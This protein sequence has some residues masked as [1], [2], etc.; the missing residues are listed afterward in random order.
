MDALLVY[1]N[2][3]SQNECTFWIRGSSGRLCVDL[4]PENSAHLWNAL[5]APIPIL[6]GIKPSEDLN[7][8]AVA[9]DALTLEQYHDI[10]Y[11]NLREHR[12]LYCSTSAAVNLNAMGKNQQKSTKMA[13]S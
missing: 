3:Q 13:I 6:S 8:E 11:W 12:I 9:T 10:C 2:I 4:I 1:A 7:Q 5:V